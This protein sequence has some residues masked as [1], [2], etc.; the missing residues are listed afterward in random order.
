[1][2]RIK[3][4]ARWIKDVIQAI[5]PVCERVFV[6][7]DHSTDFTNEIVEQM[8]ERVTLYRS[9]FA[10]IDERRDKQ[11]LLDRIM[12]CV[13]DFHLRGNPASP[14]WVLAIDGDELLA[15]GGCDT[16]RQTLHETDRQAFKLPIKYLW[17]ARDQVRVDGVYANFARPSIFRLMNAKF[18]FQETPWGGNFHCS[19]I[20]QELLH[21]AHGTCQ[22]PIL[23]LGYM[24]QA[25]RLRK[26][27]WYNQIDPH[28]AVEDCY[29]H[30]IQGDPGGPAASE[31]LLHAGPLEIQSLQGEAVGLP[32]AA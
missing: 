12:N 22:A 20:P 7:D 14:Y 31:Y 1:M 18:R 5:L 24:E 17:D 11:F 8:D 2:L 29:R 13:S 3:N 23:H 4:E 21:Q 16:I 10:G 32:L 15:E 27:A 6:L 19:S 26:H 9:I 25:D 28:N 30:V